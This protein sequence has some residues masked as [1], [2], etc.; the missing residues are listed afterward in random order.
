M[1]T[2]L[3]HLTSPRPC[4]AELPYYVWGQV[5]YDSDGVRFLVHRCAAVPVSAV[6][7]VPGAG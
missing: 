3:L 2:H 4:F 6:A 5:N 7:P 1:T